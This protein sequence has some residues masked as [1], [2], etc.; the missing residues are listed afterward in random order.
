M[1]RHHSNEVVCSP[2]FGPRIF[3][4]SSLHTIDFHL[5]I[6]FTST[7]TLMCHCT[8]LKEE[9]AAGEEAE[10][11]II[12]EADS[13][14]YEVEEEYASEVMDVEGEV[15][16]DAEYY[17]DELHEEKKDEL[18]QELANT[19]DPEKKAEIEEE[20]AE[21]DAAEQDIDEEYEEVAEE[22]EDYAEEYMDEADE[23]Y[24]NALD[25]ED[26][27]EDAKDEED[28]LAN[29]VD[30][31][32]EA[33]NNEK[34]NNNYSGSSASTEEEIVE[35]EMEEEIE[36]EEEWYWDEYPDSY[37]DDY[38]EDEYWDYDWDSVWGEYA[39]E[40]L[41]SNE[42][43]ART[44]DPNVPAGGDDEWPFVMIYGS[45]KSCEAYILDYFAEEAFEE[46]EDLKQQSIIYFVMAVAG[47]AASLVGYL[48]YRV[49]PTPANQIELLGY[50]GGVLA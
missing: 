27:Y 9:N 18:E 10:E 25:A 35:E 7:F 36:E 17:E 23:D 20:I 42:L 14:I 1:K 33:I 32:E 4:K 8:E 29:E 2:P 50:D 46:V 16:E 38:F 26:K 40:D 24:D 44:Y 22:Y 48:K 28:E 30:A 6:F 15:Y 41:F 21:N 31:T 12:D 19:D 3:R 13:E 5:T 49:S 39:C 34:Q 37:D 11:D 47:L 45:C 43:G